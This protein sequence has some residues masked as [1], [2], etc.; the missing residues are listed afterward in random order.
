M[1]SSLLSDFVLLP[2]LSFWIR[3]EK[4]CPEHV[5]TC[6]AFFSGWLPVLCGVRE[7]EGNGFLLLSSRS[8]LGSSCYP[9]QAVVEKGSAVKL[10]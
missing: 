2:Q 9:G 7:E 3:K 8:C 4:L 1:T 5:G 6:E 10:R